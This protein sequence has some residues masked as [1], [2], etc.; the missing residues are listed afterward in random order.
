M[1]K[2]IDKIREMIRTKYGDDFL[3][4]VKESPFF[5]EQFSVIINVFLNFQFFHRYTIPVKDYIWRDKNILFNYL[6]AGKPCFA[7]YDYYFT[8]YEEE[9]PDISKLK[10]DL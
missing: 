7:T 2:L 10:I 8:N 4:E 5:K 1:I 9:L 6:S 3:Y